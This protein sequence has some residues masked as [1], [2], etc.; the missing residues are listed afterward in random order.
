MHRLREFGANQKEIDLLDEGKLSME[1]MRKVA[2]MI[3]G[4]N[5]ADYPQPEADWVGF[6][7]M[8][9]TRNE[10]AG[11]IWSPVERR[12]RPWVEPT[13][14]AKAFGQSGGCSIM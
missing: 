1:Q 7:R 13:A 10:S 5:L 12:L 4:G 11:M 6:N 3:L 2:H 14:L 8:L 9:K